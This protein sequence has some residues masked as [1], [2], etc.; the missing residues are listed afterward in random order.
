MNVATRQ[1]LLISVTELA[2]LLGD[3]QLRVIDCRFDLMAPEAGRIAYLEA[4]IPGAVYADLDQDLSGPVTGDSG[5]HPLP[6]RE[7]AEA[8]FSIMGIDAATNVVCYDAAG[9]AIAS[10]AWWLLRWLGH[11]S[12]TVLDGGLQAWQERGLPLEQGSNEVDRRDFRGRPNRDWV[13]TT[14]EIAAGLFASG[15]HVLVDARDPA[16]FRGEIEPIDTKAGHIPGT[17]NLP[18][19]AGL[20]EDGTWLDGASLRRLLLPLLGAD[21][22]VPWAVMCGSGVTACHLAISGLLA[23]YSAPRV[24]IGS[25]SEWIRDP[26]RPVRTGESG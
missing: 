9:G 3:P 18:F 4:H 23:G 20:G 2:A 26:S 11:S 14:R 7:D 22:S 8:L 10:R 19:T 25:W 17:L 16:R 5:R 1:E 21:V 12:V 13:L 15:S 24:Y 6:A